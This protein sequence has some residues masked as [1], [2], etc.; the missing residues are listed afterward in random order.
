[1]LRKVVLTDQA[2]RDV[3]G[4]C[5]WWAEHRSAQQ[6][7]RWYDKAYREMA[8]LPT[9]FNR[10]PLAQENESFPFEVRQFNFGLG[11]KATHRA[12]FTIRPDM[13]LVLRVRHLSQNELTLDDL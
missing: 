12:V 10:C 7:E 6:A 11:R 5:R 9:T 2:H 13:I 8:K 1:M 3:A 4:G